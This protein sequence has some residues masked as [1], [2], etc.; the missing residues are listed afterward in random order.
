MPPF[1]DGVGLKLVRMG[2]FSG[3]YPTKYLYYE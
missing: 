2:E 3:I 1:S